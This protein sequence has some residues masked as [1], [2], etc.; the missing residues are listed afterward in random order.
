MMNFNMTAHE[1]LESID[2]LNELKQ[3]IIDCY[4][5]YGITEPIEVL[6]FNNVEYTEITIQVFMILS[7]PISSFLN[8]TE[9]FRIDLS[10]YSINGRHYYRG[11]ATYNIMVFNDQVQADVGK[12]R[13]VHILTEPSYEENCNY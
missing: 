5:D 9:P 6:L 1:V 13:F 11:M 10:H 12:Q 7:T 2:S 4:R 8:Y 3:Y